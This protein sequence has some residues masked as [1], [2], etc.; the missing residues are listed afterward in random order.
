MDTRLKNS[1]T[2]TG[3]GAN[4]Y[5]RQPGVTVWT[6]HARVSGTGAVSATVV[7]EGTNDV[8]GLVGWVTLGTITLSG[9]TE[10]FDMLTGS[11]V[12]EHMRHR[13]SAISGTGATLVVTSSGV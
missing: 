9:T 2:A 8:D 7:I 10:A 6:H 11:C 5:D 4:T 1:F 13:C 3:N 12:V